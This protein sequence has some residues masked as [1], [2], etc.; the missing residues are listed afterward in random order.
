MVGLVREIRA[1]LKPGRPVQ[2]SVNVPWAVWEVLERRCVRLRQ[3]AADVSG[4]DAAVRAEQ[5]LSVLDGLTLEGRLLSV[6]L[7]SEV[8]GELVVE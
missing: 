1:D 3:E 4:K 6:L 8:F 2:L 5:A 7:G